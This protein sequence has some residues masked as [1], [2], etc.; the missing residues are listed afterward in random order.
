MR[1]VKECTVWI[2]T[3]PD[4]P[5][6]E[7]VAAD[8]VQRR[9][10]SPEMFDDVGVLFSCTAVKV[11]PKEGDTSSREKYYQGIKFFD[12]TIVGDTPEMVG[13]SAPQ[14]HRY[15]KQ[16]AYCVCYALIRSNFRAWK[17]C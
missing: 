10:L 11:A 8:I 2:L 5:G 1:K 16:S 3:H 17:T 13:R 7:I 14:G 4:I 6:V 9:T 12:P 15:T